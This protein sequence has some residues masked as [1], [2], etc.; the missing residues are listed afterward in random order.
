MSLFSREFSINNK[1]LGET[2]A[3]IDLQTIIIVGVVGVVL[4]IF[5]SLGGY[6]NSIK[7][8]ATGILSAPRANAFAQITS[9]E[10][11]LNLLG[12]LDEVAVE[13]SKLTQRITNLE[14]ELANAE[15]IFNENERLIRETG[16]K[17]AR[18]YERIGVQ[19]VGLD[20]SQRGRMQINKGS[21]QNIA[22]GDIVV[23]GNIAVG[24]V[25][26]VEPYLSEVE[27]INANTLSIPVK[28]ASQGN[29]GLTAGVS[30]TNLVVRDILQSREVSIGDSVFTSGLNSVFPADLYLGRISALNDDERAVTKEAFVTYPVNL[31][32]EY[33]FKVLKTTE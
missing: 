1:S 23:T 22:V 25:R 26:K 18:E 9:L 5:E 21:S 3:P 14:A 30:G 27:L 28:T 8:L 6:L 2:R 7:E 24:V 29:I 4:I 15:I 20:E 10:A 32:Q 31:R 11:N 12:R 17:Y 33:Q 19:V 16:V 13:N